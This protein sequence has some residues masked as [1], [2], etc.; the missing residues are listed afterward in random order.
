M[1]FSKKFFSDHQPPPSGTAQSQVTHICSLTNSSIRL[2]RTEDK[3]H[4]QVLLPQQLPHLLPSM[5][6]L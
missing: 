4:P 1:H 5:T 6:P 2:L 3:L